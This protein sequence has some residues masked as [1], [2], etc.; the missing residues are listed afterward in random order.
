MVSFS[1]SHFFSLWLEHKVWGS[2]LIPGRN[3]LISSYVYVLVFFFSLWI[4]FCCLARSRNA[5]N[6]NQNVFHFWALSI[7]QREGNKLVEGHKLV[8]FWLRSSKGTFCQLQWCT[9]FCIAVTI[10]RPLCEDKREW[11]PPVPFS[12]MFWQEH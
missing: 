4:S 5:I 2:H 11:E 12:S 3:L 10:D 8:V 9:L 7:Y 6:K 1:R